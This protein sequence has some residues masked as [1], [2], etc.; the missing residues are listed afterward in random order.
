MMIS[1]GKLALAREIR[2]HAIERACAEMG[3]SRPT[4]DSWKTRA[5]P[6]GAI[7]VHALQG[8]AAQIY[9]S[10]AG[11]SPTIKPA[12]KEDGRCTQGN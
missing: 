7:S 6:G 4:W 3:I 10:R 9:I 8:R 5:R 1:F 11:L 2:N 12:Q